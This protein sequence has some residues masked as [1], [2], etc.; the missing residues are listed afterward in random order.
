MQQHGRTERAVAPQADAH[1]GFPFLEVRGTAAAQEDAVVGVPAREASAFN[2][3]PFPAF[4]SAT[5]GDDDPTREPP[6]PVDDLLASLGGGA[7]HS[8][9]AEPTPPPGGTTPAPAVPTGLDALGLGFDDDD[10][11]AIPDA[12]APAAD[13]RSASGIRGRFFGGPRDDEE[14]APGHDDRAV[15]GVDD[16]SSI[17][18]EMADTGYFWNLTPDPNAEDPKDSPVSVAT[19]FLGDTAADSPAPTD[20]FAGDDA[21]PTWDDE[22]GLET[23]DPEWSFTDDAAPGDT[24]PFGDDLRLAT[25]SAAGQQ[26]PFEA[27]DDDE[28]SALFGGAAAGAA[29]NDPFVAPSSRQPV[30]SGFAAAPAQG[31]GGGIGPQRN[32]GAGGGGHDGSGRGGDDGSGRGGAGGG[33]SLPPSGGNRTTRTLIWVAGG[34]VVLLVVAG[35]FF[36]G[37]QLGGGGA[38]PA[39][40]SP[41]AS[42]SETPVAAPTAPQPAGAHAWDTLFGGE[43]IEPFESVWAE[44]F[45][46]VDC[47]TPHAAQLVYRGTLPGDEAAPFPGEAALAEQMPGLCR[48]VGVFD[49]ALVAGIPD[50]QVQGSFPVTEEQWAEGQRTYYCFANRAGGEPLTASIMGP[51][52]TA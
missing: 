44:E 32:G 42:S 15:D 46:V 40:D 4:A 14:P 30:T 39:S 5:G 17:A 43:C 25:T 29:A 6:A 50:L 23:A 12:P 45:T 28:L 2:T 13:D 47:A 21:E 7:S 36:F 51:G 41:S 49:P 8:R 16:E 1:T 26:D 10:D 11:E 20:L 27:S 9:S 38:E 19:A 3:T 37:T 52:P 18:R 24:A 31:S 33:A 22:A 35:L 48:A 34:L